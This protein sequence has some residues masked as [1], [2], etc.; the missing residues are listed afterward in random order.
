MN[1]VP[2][3][4][5]RRVDLAR[6]EPIDIDL[7]DIALA[8]S[9]IPRW[10]GHTSRDWSIADHS[11]FVLELLQTYYAPN[12]SKA[13]RLAALLHDAREAY[14]G[15]HVRPLIA[16]T[17]RRSTSLITADA[18]VEDIQVDLDRA[19]AARFSIPQE[20]FY[21]PAV[22]AADNLAAV[23]EAETL[24]PA[25][26]VQWEHRISL[27]QPLPPM[28]HR[29]RRDAAQALAAAVRINLHDH[30]VRTQGPRK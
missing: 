30:Q 20:L 21:H 18:V 5:G 26:S 15:D 1:F 7:D 25:G 27:P 9:R 14:T 16:E 8:L 24:M 6:P 13:L 11:L 4:S 2:T 22:Q 29:T 28:R 3:A 17:R 12:A 10:A 19:I 23:L